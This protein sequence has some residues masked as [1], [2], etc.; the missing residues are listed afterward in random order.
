M[1]GAKPIATR[2]SPEL[3]I[4]LGTTNPKDCGVKP[5]NIIDIA[6]GSPTLLDDLET[7]I[8]NIT[9]NLELSADPFVCKP[10]ASL[11]SSLQFSI[12]VH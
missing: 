5:I 1:L 9:R 12:L 2:S 3:S 4:A 6:D 10:L 8:I 11:P 7:V